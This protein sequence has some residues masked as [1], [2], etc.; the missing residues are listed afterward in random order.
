MKRLTDK[1]MELD[2]FLNEL[3]NHMDLQ[4]FLEYS[5]IYFARGDEI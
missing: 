1:E 4:K 2:N 5:T 3:S